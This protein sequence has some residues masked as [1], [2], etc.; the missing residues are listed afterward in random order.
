MNDSFQV[1][2]DET[3]TIV[4]EFEVKT[5]IMGQWKS[6]GLLYSDVHKGSRRD[7]DHHHHLFDPKKMLEMT[8]GRWMIDLSGHNNIDHEG[9]SYAPS[10]S[11]FLLTDNG[12]GGGGSSV[13]KGGT[14]SSQG[15]NSYCRRRKWIPRG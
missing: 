8:D 13:L 9:W 11:H 4:Y 3:D 5:S 2:S 10:R 14:S 12:D 1:S 6:D 15:W 7:D